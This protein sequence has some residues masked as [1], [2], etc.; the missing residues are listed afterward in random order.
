MKNVIVA[1]LLVVAAGLGAFSIY[2]RNQLAQVRVELAKAETDLKAAQDAL[3]EKSE[4]DAKVSYAEK[5][6]KILQETLSEAS[7]AAAK[8]SQQVSKLEQSLEAAKT[9]T[10]NKGL[11]A[12]FKDPEMKEMIKTQQKMVLG[13]MIEK[14]YGDM[15][16][17]LNLTPEQAAQVKDLLKQKMLAG[18]EIGMSMLDGSLDAAKRAELG[19]QIKDQTAAYDAQIKDLLGEE[20]YTEFKSYEK[21]TG[22]RMLV[23]QFRDQLAGSAGSLNPAQEKQLIDAMQEENS[24]F[25]WT[26]SPDKYQNPGDTDFSELLSEERLN[27]L[28]TEKAALDQQVLERARQILTPDQLKQFEQFQGSQRQMQITAMKMAAKMFGVKSQ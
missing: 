20:K 5:K 22:D 11:A 10:E 8:Q 14:M 12:M 13:P 21:S 15:F 6:A 16:Q 3:Q 23:G 18:T 27:K 19:K 17:Q 28:A 1:L 9:N 4:A 26:T 7:T 2:Q 25:K 24:A